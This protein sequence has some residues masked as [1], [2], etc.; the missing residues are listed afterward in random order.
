M[1]LRLTPS[2]GLTGAPGETGAFTVVNAGRTDP[3]VDYDDTRG[4]LVIEIDRFGGL[5]PP[6]IAQNHIVKTRIYGDGKVVYVES[7][8]DPIYQGQLSELEIMGLLT[9]IRD[10]GYWQM[11][12]TLYTTPMAPTDMPTSHVSVNLRGGTSKRVSVYWGPP[13]GFTEIYTRLSAPQLQPTGVLT[14]QRQTITQAEL[15]Q[16]WYYGMEYQKKLDTPTGWTWVDAG[17]SSRWTR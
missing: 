14:Y 15:S 16:G 7:G 5:I 9:Y 3:Q 17:R 6:Q 11:S 1:R 12:D 8:S 4:Q 13:A 10:Q 2:D